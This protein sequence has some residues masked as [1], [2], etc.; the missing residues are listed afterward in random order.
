MKINIDLDELRLVFKDGSEDVNYYLDRTTGKIIAEI[1]E[2]FYLDGTPAEKEI[3]EDFWSESFPENP[4]Y[5]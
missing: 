3:I 4:R 2:P 5:I 1:D